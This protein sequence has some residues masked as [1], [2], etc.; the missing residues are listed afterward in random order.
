MRMTGGLIGT[1]V[2]PE[3]DSGIYE[4]DQFGESVASIADLD[5]D[6][7]REIMVGAPF[8]SVGEI[9]SA[10]RV[11]V[12]SGS[13][14]EFL[15]ALVSPFPENLRL[16]RRIGR[17]HDSDLELQLF[18]DD[19]RRVRDFYA[20]EHIVAI[21]ICM[22]ARRHDLGSR[23]FFA[24]RTKPEVHQ[25]ARW[26]ILNLH[27]RCLLENRYRIGP[28]RSGATGRRLCRS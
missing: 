25:V 24:G 28:L 6:G 12:F 23:R 10:G 27:L 15:F 26:I 5:G 2:N 14:H 11:Y 4:A 1:I 20:D 13:S 18:V 21:E 8:Q 22:D 9:Y 16:R 19:F 3:I 17:L 7:I